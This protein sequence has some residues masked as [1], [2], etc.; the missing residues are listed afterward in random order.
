MR[1]YRLW[2]DTFRNVSNYELKYLSLPKNL[3]ETVTMKQK[4]KQ[5]ECLKFRVEG[6]ICDMFK[7]AEIDSLLAGYQDEE[8]FLEALSR[9]TFTPNLKK[10][11]S[12][13]LLATSKQQRK[14]L[15]QD[16][17]FNSPLLKQYA[18]WERKSSSRPLK[19]SSQLQAFIVKLLRLVENPETR[20]Y[21]LSPSSLS[22]DISVEDT[23]RLNKYMPATKGRLEV[24]KDICNWSVICPN[25]LYQALESYAKHIDSKVKKENDGLPAFYEEENLISDQQQVSRLLRR[26]YYTLRDTVLFM[27][28][29]QKIQEKLRQPHTPTDCL[30]GQL[31]LDF[32]SGH[33]VLQEQLDYQE[34]EAENADILAQIAE[35]NKKKREILN[36]DDF[37]SGV[38]DDYSFEEREVYVEESPVKRFR[39]G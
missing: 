14:L 10:H 4:Y 37:S 34:T 28:T 8:Q 20:A 19:D 17:V 36:R 30:D 3:Q 32:C 2:V 6:K 31:M 35:E 15:Q 27:Q 9:V 21:V 29:Y 25:P 12:Y 26:N 22:S 1:R 11:H 7:L 23:K 13:H 24:E 5:C 38:F 16:L 33:P 39:N 18:I